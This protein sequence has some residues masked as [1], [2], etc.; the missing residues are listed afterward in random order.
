MP[1]VRGRRREVGT[2]SPS[3]LSS[4]SGRRASNRAKPGRR[5]GAEAFL[6][7]TGR[8]L[9]DVAAGKREP[10]TVGQPV[11]SWERRVSQVHCSHWSGVQPRSRTSNR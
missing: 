4:M 2:G 5:G 10:G 3:W 9:D 8:V 7:V 1:Q 6:E 11:Q